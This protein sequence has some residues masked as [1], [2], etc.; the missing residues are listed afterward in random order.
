MR[1]SVME[2]AR[3]IECL[4]PYL[5]GAAQEG[6]E[7]VEFVERTGEAAARMLGVPAVEAEAVGVDFA[8][9]MFTR[10]MRGLHE[11]AHCLRAYVWRAAQWFAA[12]QARLTR[13]QAMLAERYL[14]AME[15]ESL[16]TD[17]LVE[18]RQ[19]LADIEAAVANL[20]P[21]EHAVYDL[22]SPVN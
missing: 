10:G 11:H 20:R 17:V 19:L 1:R 6:A 22:A 14:A 21:E 3:G 4:K 7:A 12:K 18:R 2:W 13:K 9:H 16:T 8:A 15:E 5:D